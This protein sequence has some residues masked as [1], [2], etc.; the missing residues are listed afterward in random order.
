MDRL[1]YPELAPTDVPRFLWQH[2]KTVLSTFAAGMAL[3]L[4]YFALAPRKYRS[5]AKVLVRIGR[6]SITLDPQHAHDVLEALLTTAREDHARVHRTRGSQEF[7]EIQRELLSNDLREQE[8]GLR[9]FK[10][11]HGLASLPTQRDAEVGI[12]AALQSDLL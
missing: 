3:T 9:D 11:T 7:F 8:Q 1:N 4:L 10:D 12:I 2:R 6:E 5:E